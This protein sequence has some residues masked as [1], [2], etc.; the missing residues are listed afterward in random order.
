MFGFAGLQ[1]KMS[2]NLP[3]EDRMSH[4]EKVCRKQ[5]RDAEWQFRVSKGY[6]KDTF[7]NRMRF[8]MT[9]KD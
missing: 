8:R 6:E 7:W 3:P 1:I 2:Q 5:A 9:H 4:D